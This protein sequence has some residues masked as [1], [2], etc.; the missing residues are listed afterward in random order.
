MTA[1]ERYP[2]KQ[3]TLHAQ[4]QAWLGQLRRSLWWHKTKGLMP[5]HSVTDNTQAWRQRWQERK[6]FKTRDKH[7]EGNALRNTT[8]DVEPGTL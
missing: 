3:A 1:Q 5:Q 2:T 7:I 8:H 4:I 6:A